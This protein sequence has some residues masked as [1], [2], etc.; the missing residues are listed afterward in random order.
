METATTFAVA[1]YFGMDRVAVLYVFDN[2]RRREHI[3]LTDVEKD[4][5]RERGNQAVRGLAF[6][7]ALEFDSKY[8]GKGAV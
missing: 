1:E 8:K 4:A 7:L 2:P 3:L 6:G 5:K